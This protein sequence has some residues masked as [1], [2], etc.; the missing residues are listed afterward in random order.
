MDSGTLNI[1][2]V[3]VAI[4]GVGVAI[5]F[6]AKQAA[7]KTKQTQT[8]NSGANSIQSG[9]D[10]NIGQGSGS[11]TGIEKPDVKPDVNK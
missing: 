9:R 7:N 5:Y 2:G 4:V 11:D 1:I 3:V 10:T 8:Q 6:G